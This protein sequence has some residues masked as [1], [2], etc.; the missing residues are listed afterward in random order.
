KKAQIS[1]GKSQ[2]IEFDKGT[3][4]YFTG[5]PGKILT[6]VLLEC[7]RKLILACNYPIIYIS[8]KDREEVI[9]RKLLE[10]WN[11][12][13]QVNEPIKKNRIIKKFI[14]E[15][16]TMTLENSIH[17][18]YVNDIERLKDIIFKDKWECIFID[19]LSQLKRNQNDYREIEKYETIYLLKEY[20]ANKMIN[21]NI[22]DYLFED[23]DVSDIVSCPLYLNKIAEI[24]NEIFFIDKNKKQNDFEESILNKINIKSF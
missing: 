10:L 7:F 9:F 1:F 17:I 3:L 21:I 22:A 24:V 11:I 4:N 15:Y 2:T 18:V 19:N 8:T 20:A 5:K 12:G 14:A 16:G 23:I 6:E 13:P